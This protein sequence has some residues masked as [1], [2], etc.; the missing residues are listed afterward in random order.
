M[1]FPKTRKKQLFQIFKH[2]KQFLQ[3]IILSDGS[4]CEVT[5][6]SNE[7]PA[8]KLVVDSQCHP[9]W[10]TKLAAHQAFLVN[11]GQI[12]QYNKKYADLMQESALSP[13]QVFVDM[14]ENQ[15]SGESVGKVR[16]VS[17]IPIIEDSKEESEPAWMKFKRAAEA[18]KNSST[19]TQKKTTKN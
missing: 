15:K 16:N 14:L 19:T 7:R 1:K 10:N 12:L 6:L 4:I 18:A 3:R 5:S 8:I 11:Q 17:N 13:D 9:S 2:P